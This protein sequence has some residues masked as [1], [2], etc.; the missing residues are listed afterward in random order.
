MGIKF[1]QNW[2]IRIWAIAE[3]LL[4]ARLV[5]RILAAR[6]DNPFI[7]ALYLLSE[8]L[9][10]PLVA[11]DA[12]QPLY[13]AVLELSTLAMAALVA[14]IALMLHLFEVKQGFRKRAM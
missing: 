14:A 6:P 13:G 10:L 12:G 11:L 5:A 3:T 2:L 8:P 9:R 1:R 4:L 7:V